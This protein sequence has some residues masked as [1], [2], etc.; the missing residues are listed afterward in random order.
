MGNLKRGVCVCVCVC[1]CV[2]VSVCLCVCV[3][4]CVSRS[5]RAGGQWVGEGEAKCLDPLPTGVLPGEVGGTR[6]D[7]S[8]TGCRQETQQQCG[9]TGSVF[10]RPPRAPQGLCVC[11]CVFV[12]IKF[13]GIIYN[14]IICECL[15]VL[16]SG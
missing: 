6:P 4:V 14:F 1:M 5:W 3:C 9:Q 16:L 15:F 7:S 11:V 13:S 12:S 2:C 10:L 8:C